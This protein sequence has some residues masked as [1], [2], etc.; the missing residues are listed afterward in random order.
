MEDPLSILIAQGLISPKVAEEVRSEV[1]SKKIDIDTALRNRGFSDEEI[2]AAEQGGSVRIPTRTIGDSKI[3]LQILQ[4]IPEESANHYKF[5]ALGIEDGVLE[6]GFVSPDDIEAVD[7]LNFITRKAGLPYK[8]FHITKADFEKVLAMYRGLTGDVGNAL[9]ELAT[10]ASSDQI[11][12]QAELDKQAQ[13][14]KDAKNFQE[15]API[16]KIVATVLRYAV[17]GSAS[18]VHIEPSE[19]GVRVRFRVDGTLHTSL[20]LPKN[21][22]QA[23]VARIK[24][25][26]ALRLDERRKPQDGRF[27]ATVSGRKIDFRVSTFPLPEGEKVVMRILDK[28]KG[29]VPLADLGLS[30]KNLTLIRAALERPYGLIL[31]SGPTGSGKSTTL[32]S[33][34]N[35]LDRESENVMSL[36]DPVEYHMEGVNQSQMRPEIGYTFASGLRTALRQDPDII[37]V[38][39]IRDAETAKL[40]IQ[41]ALTGHLVLSTIHTN[42]SVGVIPRLIDMGVDPYLIA[43]TLILAV[44][45]RL[46]RKLHPGT[47]TEIPVSPSMRLMME[48][49]QKDLPPEYRFTIPN[50]VYDPQPTSASA[51]GMRGRSAVIEAFGMSAEVERAILDRK[52]DDEIL[53]IIRSK[54]MLTM[55]EDAMLK[56]FNK[57]IP[58]SE[59]STLGGVLLAEEVALQEEKNK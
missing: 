33:M 13:G 6:V 20:M 21:T 11:D 32:Y 31:V 16:I 18:D 28:N 45:Q 38:G 51:S 56:A 48:E 58:F 44:A 9:D 41:A 24:V 53:K 23:I 57:V 55:R 37:M 14:P 10:E 43:P 52:G 59:I 8:V 17:D 42:D 27:S 36:E 54:G 35:E 25:L 5:V 12:V 34:L 1:E 46:V 50:V 29:V 15:D 22:Q 47:G 49:S 4:N 30:S 3:A 39:E 40:A 19:A 2:L 7:A 26:A